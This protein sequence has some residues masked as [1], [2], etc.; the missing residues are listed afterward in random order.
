MNFTPEALIAVI[1]LAGSI[2]GAMAIVAFS[3][4]R[5]EKAID[6]HNQ[7]FE[8]I[9]EKFSVCQLREHESMGNLRISM[10]ETNGKFDVIM[11]RLDL[12][13]ENQAELK[14]RLDNLTYPY[15][16]NRG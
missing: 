9:W 14:K 8:R 6:Q 12:I 10:T 3:R 4:Q 2:S 7:E 16:N 11:Q 1:S 13:A 15:N 5:M